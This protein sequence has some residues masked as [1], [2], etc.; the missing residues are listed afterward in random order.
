MPTLAQ[1]SRRVLAAALVA[2]AVVGCGS[3]AHVKPSR[4][5]EVGLTEY[6]VT[7]QRIEAP[8]GQLSIYV[9]NLGRLTHNLSVTSGTESVETTKPIPPGQSAWLFLVLAPGNYGL[10]STLFSDQALGAYGT[11][12]VH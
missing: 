9:R 1:R 12:I 11:L 8:A 7:P 10:A 2:G 3:T 5:I 4:S 6:R